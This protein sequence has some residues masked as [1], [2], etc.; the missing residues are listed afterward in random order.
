M[1]LNGLALAFIVAGLSGGVQAGVSDAQL[2][3][4]AGASWLHTNGNLAAH[5]FSTLDQINAGNA[6]KLKVAWIMSPG[7][8]TDAQATPSYHEG[9][10]YFPQDNK[11][12]AVDGGT[13]NILWKYE[14]KLPDDWG[15]YNVPFFHRQAPWP[16]FGRQQRLLPVERCKT[17]LDRHEDGQGQ[18]GQ[19][20]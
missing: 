18:L 6:K 15:G 4:E 14:H 5:R 9:V 11:V 20:L 12:F 2:S 8:K 13:G 1:K 17:A 3:A 7:G 10:L 19:V 16:G